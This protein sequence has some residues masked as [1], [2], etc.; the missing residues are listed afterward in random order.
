MH[1]RR[2]EQRWPAYLGGR[3]VFGSRRV[4]ADCLV[5]NTSAGGARL[6][7]DRAAL[8]PDEFSLQIPKHQT[9]YKVRTCWRRFHDVGVELTPVQTVEPVDLELTRRMRELEASNA[10]L[11]RRLADMTEA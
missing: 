1:E 8:L 7:L 3:I 5:R 2:R 6:V 10:T 9:E 4:T 11:K